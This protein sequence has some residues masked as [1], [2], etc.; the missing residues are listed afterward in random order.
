MKTIQTKTQSLLTISLSITSH[1]FVTVQCDA[2]HF[3]VS[4][5]LSVWCYA[6]DILKTASK[7]Y[8]KDTRMSFAEFE[9]STLTVPIL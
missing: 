1:L 3:F 9:I 5:I 6:A 4:I 8:L 7:F 2:L